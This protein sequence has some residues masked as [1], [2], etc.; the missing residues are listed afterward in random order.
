MADESLKLFGFEIRKANKAADKKMLPSIVPPIDEDGAGYIT[1]AGSHYGTYVDINGDTGTKDDAQQIK[2]YRGM[3]LHPEV[4]AALEDI[5]NEAISASSNEQPVSLIL[6]KVKIS[7]SIKKQMVEEFDHIVSMLDFKEHGHD[8]FKRWYIDGRMY[9]HLVVDEKNLK[10]GIQEI[11]PI[12]AA[13]TRKIK[14]ITKK[15]D[16]L[17]G[18]SIIEKVDEFFLYQEKP[19]TSTTGIK[20]SADSVSYVTSGL[21]DEDRKKVVSHLHKALKPVNQL[22][23]MEDSLVIY[24]LA[25]APERRIFYIDV[26]N[27]PRG[28]AEEYMKGIMSRYRNK[29]VYDANTGAIRDDRKH[30]SMLEDFWLPRRE[31]GR[32]T[33]ISTLSGGE[34]LGQIEDVIYFQKRLYRS[35]N[36]PVNRLEQENTFS[37]GRS[38]EITRDELKF[39]KFIE[40]IRNRFNHLFY[41]ILKKQ[42]IIKGIITEQDWDDWKNDLTVDYINDN[43]FTELRDAEILRDRMQNLDQI[44]QHIGQYF[45]KEWVMKNVLQM[46]DDDIKQMKKEM[47]EELKNGEYD[48]MGMGGD[49][50]QQPQPGD[51]AQPEPD[52]SGQPG[53]ISGVPEKPAEQAIPGKPKRNGVKK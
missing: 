51:E 26:G 2:Q 18:A 30:M 8:M 29:L 24:R 42:L 34:N 47:D 20:L 48:N 31:G 40:R 49:D 44:S 3:A 53:V 45:S 6:D 50:E 28:K 52:K 15:K 9:H 46:D 23:M 36:V 35:L 16:P 5:V 21:L 43:H 38:T 4:D 39:H 37:V 19:G 13:K 1:A 14:Q 22:R 41:N 7:D 11:R 27:L 17:T 32:G 33:E 25:R 10:A 12:D